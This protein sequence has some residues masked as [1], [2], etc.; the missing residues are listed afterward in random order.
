MNVVET[1]GSIEFDKG[2][3][4]GRIINVD[5]S[6]AVIDIDDHDLLTRVAVGNL[7]AIKGATSFEFLI[8]LVDRVTREPFE[9]TLL[10]E[11]D[12]KG[13]VPV[14][15]GQ[16]D[17][18]RVVLVGTYRTV[19]GARRNVLKRGADSFPQIDR[20]AFLVE[21]EKLQALMSLFAV[22]LADSERLQLGK[23]LSDPT[24]DAIADGN[25]LFQRHAALLGSTGTGKSWTVALI[26]ERAAALKHPNLIVF[27]MHGEYGPLTEDAGETKAVAEGFHIAG[28]GDIA[29][30]PEDALFLPYWILNQ[31]EM[32]A[33]LLDRSEQNA[34]N[35]AS[36]FR[37]HVRELKLQTLEAEGKSDV[38]STF[39]VDSPI[40][41][42]LDELIKRLKADDEGTVPGKNDKPIKGPYNGKLT[43]FIDRLESKRG[44]RRYA[45]LLQPPKE[46][47]KYEWLAAQVRR[48]LCSDEEHRGIKVLDF[49]EVPSDVLPVVAGVLARTLYDV[50]FWMT[51]SERTPLAFVCD[52]AHLYLPAVDD[53]DA[54]EC[55]ALESFERIAKEGRKY[56]VALLVVSQRPSDVSRTILSQCN[57]FL[58][59]RLTNDRDQ[60]V[61]RRFVSDSLA[62][63]IDT[64]PLL[65]V[66]EVLIL[67]DAMLLP[68]RVK[69]AEPRI[70]P[71]SATRDFWTDW[72]RV[73][74][75]G[76]AIAASVEA[77]RRQVRAKAG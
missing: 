4:L 29:S 63:L 61:V 13:E 22:D 76:D 21:G 23:F 44:D 53:T 46:T 66:G 18:V 35:Q 74:P 45:F 38:A 1:N 30:A 68:T 6:R 60:G 31:E 51:E 75:N 9:E 48:L 54:I 43:R 36:R 73:E 24:A 3:L 71:D 62:G 67:G 69:L 25:K 58:A 14:E 49:S 19:D 20:E 16:R 17:L 28:P 12:E 59:M 11:E 72:G 65:D 7:V 34:P 32:L 64:L 10:E 15:E 5:T 52:E 26:L 39:T 27:D 41:Y 77:L 47:L 2:G 37:T 57:N 8:G 56:G 55:R 40:P 33:L 50:Q 42:S 70:K